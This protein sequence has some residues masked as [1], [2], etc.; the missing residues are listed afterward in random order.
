MACRHGVA[1]A[2]T[3]RI[4]RASPACRLESS[5]GTVTAELPMQLGMALIFAK[6]MDRM[7]AFYRDAIGLEFLPGESSVGWA[8]FNAG[9]ARRCSSQPTGAVTASIRKGT[10]FRS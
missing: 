8:V 7:T 2:G 4:D 10:S 3:D 5:T 1:Q 6:D 9:K